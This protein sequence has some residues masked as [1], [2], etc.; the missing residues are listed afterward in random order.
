MMK[1]THVRI[2]RHWHKPEISIKVTNKEIQIE[3]ELADFI[4]ALAA[5]IGNPAGILTRAQLLAKL[6]AAAEVVTVA[7]K[8]ETTPLAGG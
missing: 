3:L 4:R 2:S 8:K 6:E 5:E 1:G 7:M